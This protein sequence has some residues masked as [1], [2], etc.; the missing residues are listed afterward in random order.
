M[1]EMMIFAVHYEIF[2]RSLITFSSCWSPLSSWPLLHAVVWWLQ[3][4]PNRLVLA[5][6]SLRRE[7][8]RSLPDVS[9]ARALLALV[10]K[11][12]EL[13]AVQPTMKARRVQSPFGS[14]SF[15]YD[16]DSRFQL[17][18]ERLLLVRHLPPIPPLHCLILRCRHWPLPLH[19]QTLRPRLFL[20]VS[21]ATSWLP[22]SCA[23]AR[24]L[25]VRWSDDFFPYD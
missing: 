23:L 14:T 12:L 4:A 10:V 3:V 19:F 9:D 15:E 21:C 20:V 18:Y 1:A 8:F 7:L 5:Q 2:L 25:Q 17:D 22:L 13:Q 6:F 11:V 16:L 24:A